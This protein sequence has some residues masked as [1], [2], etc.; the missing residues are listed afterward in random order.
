MGDASLR[1]VFIAL[2]ILIVIFFWPMKFLLVCSRQTL[3][4]TG[5]N[6]QFLDREAQ[7]ACRYGTLEKRP[8]TTGAFRMEEEARTRAVMIGL[9]AIIIICGAILAGASYWSDE[10]LDHSPTSTDSGRVIR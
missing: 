2:T 1:S 5:R 9:L 6:Q 7:D 8:C 10:P 4:H 3:R